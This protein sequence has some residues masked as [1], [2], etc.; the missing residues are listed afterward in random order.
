[1]LERKI[2]STGFTELTILFDALMVIQ[3]FT[4]KPLSIV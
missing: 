4:E 2:S 3:S 1:M